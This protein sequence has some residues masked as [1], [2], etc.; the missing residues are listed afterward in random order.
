MI[1]YGNNNIL[2]GNVQSNISEDVN[3]PQNM[4]LVPDITLYSK[5]SLDTEVVIV[6]L[7]KHEIHTALDNSQAWYN[8]LNRG[9]VVDDHTNISIYWP[10]ITARYFSVDTNR[11][12]VTASVLSGLNSNFVIDFFLQYNGTPGPIIYNGRN[13][14]QIGTLENNKNFLLTMQSNE[15]LNGTLAEDNIP[16][17]IGGSGSTGYLILKRPYIRSISAINSGVPYHMAIIRSGTKIYM[18]I[19]GIIQGSADAVDF[20]SYDPMRLMSG[21]VGVC[22]GYL[23]NF[24]IST[25]TDRGW[26]KDFNIPNYDHSN[27]GYTKFLL[28][29]DNLTDLMGGY[30]VTQAGGTTP[31]FIN[32]WNVYFHVPAI[33]R[34]KYTITANH[35][36]DYLYINLPKCSNL[37]TYSLKFKFTAGQFF[38]I[39]FYSADG[40]YINKNISG[41]SSS[42]YIEN[43]GFDWANQ[44]INF[45]QHN[46]EWNQFF[47][48]DN[49]KNTSN[50]IK[51]GYDQS[52]GTFGTAY[53]SAICGR[54]MNHALNRYDGANQSATTYVF[55]NPVYNGIPLYI[56]GDIGNLR[57]GAGNIYNDTQYYL[58]EA[59]VKFTANPTVS[60]YLFHSTCAYGNTY[61]AGIQLNPNL[62][63]SAVMTYRYYYH[64]NYV[65]YIR[66]DVYTDTL[67]QN[68][69]GSSSS[70]QL[71]KWYHLY[72]V[73]TN[74]IGISNQTRQNVYFTADNLTTGLREIDNQILL[75][76][77]VTYYTYYFNNS[78]TVHPTYGSTYY[79]YY[80][81]NYNFGY[82]TMPMYLNRMANTSWVMAR[83]RRSA[84]TRYAQPANFTRY[85]KYSDYAASF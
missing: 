77:A 82:F 62:S 56:P 9:V 74:E 78:S 17:Q 69:S 64:I 55:D 44:T 81:T 39:Y 36:G 79:D 57:I 66:N 58:I 23:W 40:K 11:L 10:K 61:Q 76:W 72:F 85:Y 19:N 53:E 16:Y 5:S 32:N 31:S 18:A 21:Y 65:H 29:S 2:T 6:D 43:N 35:S 38:A 20:F 13:T 14:G 75:N 1:I 15:L 71:N 68:A 37:T 30:T 49:E 3:K 46:G 34:C 59:I 73:F 8:A 47:E 54:A 60:E 24:R 4:V 70:L 41:N 67:Y 27:D 63:F 26:T 12:D 51:V 52:S 83:I 25:V 84:G 48:N 7:K 28:R 50:M 33:N 42:G 80:Y 22:N 45:R